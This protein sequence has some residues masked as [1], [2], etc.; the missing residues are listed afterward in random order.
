MEKYLKY[1]S[2]DGK[3]TRSEYWGVNIISYLLLIPVVLLGLLFTL[4]GIMGAVM[5]GLVILAGVVGLTW[6]VIATSVRRCRDIGINVWFA[7]SIFIPWFGFIPWI[8][9]GCLSTEKENEHQC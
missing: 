3:A 9:F 8:V 7:L 6:V 2:F 1:L 4:G 5:G